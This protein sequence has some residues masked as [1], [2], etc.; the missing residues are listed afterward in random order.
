MTLDHTPTPPH[1]REVSHPLGLLCDRIGHQ[2]EGLC[3]VSTHRTFHPQGTVVQFRK[4]CP[5]VLV[6]MALAQWQN[7]ILLQY[8]EW[9]WSN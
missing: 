5:L 7:P 2:E 6:D 4:L 9:A 3:L 1:L 8:N